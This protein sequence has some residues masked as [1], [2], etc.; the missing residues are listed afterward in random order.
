MKNTHEEN[1]FT[2]IIASIREIDKEHFEKS[3]SKL[4]KFSEKLFNYSL[5]ITILPISVLFL[6]NK[7][8][9]LD[10]EIAKS[11]A[12]ISFGIGVILM[13]I[14]LMFFILESIISA[15]KGKYRSDTL[16]NR[17]RF[18]YPT[19]KAQSNKL[20]KKF[21]IHELTSFSEWVEYRIK[22]ETKFALVI[23]AFIAALPSFN[24]LLT[25]FKVEA[26]NRFSDANITPSQPLNY[27]FFPFSGDTI[28]LFVLT[29]VFAIQFIS[30]RW[31]KVHFYASYAA[32]RMKEKRNL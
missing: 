17:A 29:I 15:F 2:H 1:I 18:S 13:A 30:V 31:S 14:F 5:F 23:G 9:V 25:N 21:S 28:A 8:A 12:T 6:M 24:K 27:D 32:N 26:V 10:R 4:Q 11:M 19:L 7:M 20:T 16:M 3:K 22:S